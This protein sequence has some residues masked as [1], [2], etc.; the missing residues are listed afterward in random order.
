MTVVGMSPKYINYLA[1][2]HTPSFIISDN[3]EL[4]L[5]KQ[6]TVDVQI[7]DMHFSLCN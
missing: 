3:L 6:G 1:S 2:T 7:H 4:T 5:W